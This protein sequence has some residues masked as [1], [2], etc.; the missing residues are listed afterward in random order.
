M[1]VLCMYVK[2]GEMLVFFFLFTGI[3]GKSIAHVAPVK[4]GKMFVF[5]GVY[6]CVKAK[7]TFV[8]FPIAFNLSLSPIWYLVL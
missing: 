8:F 6:V 5:T 3:C 4:K 7:L 2:N 1:L